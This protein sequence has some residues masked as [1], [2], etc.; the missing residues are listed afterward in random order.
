MSND[1][2]V[3]KLS[4]DELLIRAIHQGNGASR[5]EIN[6]RQI[7]RKMPVPKLGDFLLDEL[8]K[9]RGVERA[10][11]VVPDAGD[12]LAEI[13]ISDDPDMICVS[14]RKMVRDGF[15]G[16]GMRDIDRAWSYIRMAADNPRV[17]DELPES[18][19]AFWKSASFHYRLW[20]AEKK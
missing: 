13:D 3:S 6:R 16:Q 1:I 18:G 14:A 9:S 5:H 17:M 20:K 11:P 15:K 4:I 7:E 10:T 19:T 8:M 12:D 2:H